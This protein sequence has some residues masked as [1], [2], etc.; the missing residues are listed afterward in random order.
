[1]NSI[2]VGASVSGH[3]VW[4]RGVNSPADNS[5]VTLPRAALTSGM[6]SCFMAP[7]SSTK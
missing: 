6:F 7:K 2:A 5:L 1:M 3:L 4:G